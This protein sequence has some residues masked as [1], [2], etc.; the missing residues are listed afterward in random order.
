MLYRYGLWD[1]FLSGQFWWMHLMIFTWLLFGM[2]LFIFE[3]LVFGKWVR[4]RGR[5]A[6]R[7]TLA[8]MLRLHWALLILSLVTIFAAVV[9]SHGGL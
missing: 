9:G 6:P 1:R 3:P 8:L 2:M 7:S 4:R 5:A